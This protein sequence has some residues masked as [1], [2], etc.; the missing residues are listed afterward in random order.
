[1]QRME[2]RLLEGT[3]M[4]ERPQILY[5]L[6]VRS[7]KVVLVEH[8]SV[9]GDVKQVQQVTLKDILP[10]MGRDLDWKSY[11]YDNP[12]NGRNFAFHILADEERDLRFVCFSDAKVMRRV[13]FAFL[14]AVQEA[15]RGSYSIERVQTAT[16]Y[17]MDAEF[18][19]ALQQLMDK[20]NSPEGDRLSGLNEKVKAINET[21]ME[22]LSKILER[23]EKIDLLVERAGYLESTSISFHRDTGRLRR[24]MWW[25]NVRIIAALIGLVIVLL[26]IIVVAACGITFKN[27]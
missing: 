4:K 22:S 1:M 12:H 18:R 21:L 16:D 15:F 20:Y 14:V 8:S 10:G 13:A 7:Q 19:P 25:K 27:C 17:G 9:Q 11:T 2:G 26:L 6:V 23:R 3:E 24:H 5:A